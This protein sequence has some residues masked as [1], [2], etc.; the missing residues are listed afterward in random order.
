MCY[1]NKPIIVLVILIQ[2]KKQWPCLSLVSRNLLI[3][4]WGGA[5][6]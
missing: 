2:V 5:V 3:V 1:I 4:W 6:L